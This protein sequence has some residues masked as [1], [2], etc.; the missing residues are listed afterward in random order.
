MVFYIKGIGRSTW[1][2]AKYT[3]CTRAHG[4]G[5]IDFVFTCEMNVSGE[6]FI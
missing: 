6:L 5:L 4:V 2:P 1:Q 3:Y